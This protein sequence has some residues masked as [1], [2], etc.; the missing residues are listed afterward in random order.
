[1]SEIPKIHFVSLFSVKLDADM[2]PYFVP[3]YRDLNLDSYLIFLHE[4]ENESENKF[5]EET[6]KDAGFNV[7]RVIRT[8]SF[9]EGDLRKRAV[10][11]AKKSIPTTDYIM[12]ADSDEIQM[13]DKHPSEIV[14]DNYDLVLGITFDRFDTALKEIDHTLSL[15]ENYPL[16]SANLH[17]HLFPENPRPRRKILLS[18]ASY[19]IDYT[20]SRDINI[21]KDAFSNLRVHGDVPIQ[22][23]FWRD[24][25][26]DRLQNR[27]DY[28][29]S[30]LREI[31]RFFSGVEIAPAK[32]LQ[33]ENN[34]S[35]MDVTVT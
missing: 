3:H 23:Y 21:S 35:N 30:E 22:H 4:S 7:K 29:V 18:R 10:E 9:G 5:C 16:E 20:A 19:S 12:T 17:K 24:N 27:R 2:I 31:K 13:W 1:M 26:F 32:P 8:A 25:I 14:H 11:K 6:M 28:T 33:L 34:N 15:E